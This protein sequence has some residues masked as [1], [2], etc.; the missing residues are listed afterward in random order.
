MSNHSFQNSNEVSIKSPTL[1]KSY[2]N[3]TST[4]APIEPKVARKDKKAFN[5]EP[6]LQQTI[7]S[8]F[9]KPSDPLAS[10]GKF[11]YVLHIGNHRLYIIAQEESFNSDSPKIPKTVINKYK[12]KA[13]AKLTKRFQQLRKRISLPLLE[14]DDVNVKNFNETVKSANKTLSIN[15]NTKIHCIGLTLISAIYD[16]VTSHINH[17]YGSAF[18]QEECVLDLDHGKQVLQ[19]FS[20]D[21][22][23]NIINLFQTPSDCIS[24]FEYHLPALIN[25]NSFAN[26]VALAR[27]FLSS[28]KFFERAINVQKKLVEIG[29]LANIESRLLLMSNMSNDI[30]IHKDV[31]DEKTK[32]IQKLQNY[33]TMYQKLINGFVKRHLENKHAAIHEHIQ[34][35]IDESMY[36]RMSIMEEIIAYSERSE[37]EYRNGYLRH[38]HSYNQF[39]HHYILIIYGLDENAQFSRE[40]IKQNYSNIIMDINSQ[41]QDPVMDEYFI[42]GFDMSKNDGKGNVTVEMEFFHQSGSAMTPIEKRLY[43][44]MQEL[45]GMHQ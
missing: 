10:A 30:N 31:N 15:S 2:D 41:L 6:L 25:Q 4:P 22:F 16:D 38:Q 19:I 23:I 45:S 5:L 44:Q 11:D 33:S 21:S 12:Q 8:A 34:T 14:A 35:I 29:L 17:D 9:L 32:L 18:F 24:F 43:E 27:H 13:A 42:L 36:T 28:P 39:G 1:N 37:E 3:R 40:A 26:E 20:L 7:F